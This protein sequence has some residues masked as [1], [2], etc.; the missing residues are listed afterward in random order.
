MA[1]TEIVDLEAAVTLTLLGEVAEMREATDLN[2]IT[3]DRSALPKTPRQAVASR[4]DITTD[5]DLVI[6]K[7]QAEIIVS[8]KDQDENQHIETRHR[9]NLGHYLYNRK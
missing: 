6:G 4:D 8:A 3:G 9:P 7:S 1:K 2:N 5:R